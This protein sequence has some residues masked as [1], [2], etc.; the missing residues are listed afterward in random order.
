MRCASREAAAKERVVDARGALGEPPTSGSS[1]S[2]RLVQDARHLGRLHARARSRRAAGRRGP[3]ARS[4]GRSGASGRRCARGAGGIAR[5]RSASCASRQ[6]CSAIE[7]GARDLGVKL[8]RHAARLLVVALRD[9]DQRGLVGVVAEL[10]AERL[11]LLEQAPELLGR[12]ASRG[13]RARARDL[14]GARVG[15][16]RGG[17]IVRSSQSNSARARPRWWISAS[18]ALSSSNVEVDAVHADT[19][20][21]K[22]REV[23]LALL[24]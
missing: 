14:L 12:R 4:S 6:A 5:S 19:R 1:A 9:A 13:G 15:A 17:I 22:R 16:A 11:E 18:F 10:L 24:G 21:R 20:S 2:F 23:G 7:P 3:R 8:D